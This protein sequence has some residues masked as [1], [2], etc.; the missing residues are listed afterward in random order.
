[1]RDDEAVERVA[2]NLVARAVSLTLSLGYIGWED[3]A[4]LGEGHWEAVCKR[5]TEIADA[6]APMS[7]SFE[8]AMEHLGDLASG[9]SDV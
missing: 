2:G 7:A 8:A 5:A 3:Y 9:R 6:Q 4:D 1:M